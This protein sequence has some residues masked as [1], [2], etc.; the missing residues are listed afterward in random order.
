MQIMVFQC[1]LLID[2]NVW[3][4]FYTLVL[5]NWV[6]EANWAYT[7]TLTFNDSEQRWWHRV[8]DEGRKIFWFWSNM[9]QILNVFYTEHSITEAGLGYLALKSILSF[10]YILSD[11]YLKSICL[12]WLH[13]PQILWAKSLYKTFGVVCEYFFSQCIA[14]IRV[15]E[16]DLRCTPDVIYSNA[17]QLHVLFLVSYVNTSNRWWDSG[18]LRTVCQ[19]NVMMLEYIR[20]WGSCCCSNTYI[21]LW[22]IFC[23][24]LAPG[25]EVYIIVTFCD[26]GKAP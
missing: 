4:F 10:S 25:L 15:T 19:R 23:A 7:A 14:Q 21:R 13:N 2:I 22:K 18:S 8:P 6:T 1:D 20:Q 16:Q 17:K 5:Y 12:P 26:F 3:H 11:L 24:V 9:A